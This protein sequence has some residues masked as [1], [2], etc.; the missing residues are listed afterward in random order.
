[1]LSRASIPQAESLIRPYVRRTPVMELTPHEFSLDA[2]IF[3]KLELMQHTASFK[4]RGA[5]HRIL[6]NTVPAAGVIAASGGNHGIATA[7]AAHQLGIPAEIF[8]PEI[9]SPVKVAR[10]RDYGA[11]VNVIGKNYLEALQA[12]TIRATETGALI[13]HAYD[14]W[15][16]LAGQGTIGIELEQQIPDA[17]SVLVAT[18][19][20]G[21]IGGIAAWLERRVK[22]INV[23]PELSPALTK[24]L[25]QGRPVDVQPAGIAIDSLG[26]SSCGALMFPIAQQFVS[27]S[28]LVTDDDIREAQRILW[29]H[30]RL[31]AEPGGATAFAALLSGKYKPPPRE[32]VVVLVCGGNVQ[33]ESVPQT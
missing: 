7:Y 27:Q 33:P 8:V 31:M 1:M 28:I 32:C 13:V 23:E 17:D 10:L 16:T 26:A 30:F 14:Q 22:V 2:R 19:G 12:S 18:G 11:T 4:P 6:A 24:A 3:L 21:L 5:F 9:S 20:G 29:R 15:E 25:E